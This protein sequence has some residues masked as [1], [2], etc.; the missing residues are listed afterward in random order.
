VYGGFDAVNPI[1]GGFG[2]WVRDESKSKN[3]NPVQL[4]PPLACSVAA[5]LCAEA[6]VEHFMEGKRVVLRFPKSDQLA[7]SLVQAN[8]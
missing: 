3:A 4:T 8:A 6:G 7:P 2:E 1:P 5:I